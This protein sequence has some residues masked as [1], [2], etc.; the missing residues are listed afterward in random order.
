[1]VKVIQVNPRDVTQYVG[2]NNL[3]WPFNRPYLDRIGAKIPF[4]KHDYY[5]I[6]S[7][8][9][10]QPIPIERLKK[11]K[12]VKDYLTCDHYSHSMWYKTLTNQLNNKGVAI[13][14]HRKMKCHQELNLFFE[15]YL[16]P[17]I[18]SLHTEGYRSGES[19]GLVT[20]GK[21]G[22]IH[23][24]NAADHRFF[25]ARILKISPVPVR[26]KGVHEKCHLAKKSYF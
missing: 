22:E 7:A 16:N 18:E 23:K 3:R 10:R 13:H 19:I 15:Q 4:L 12:K 1:M 21:N 24:A 5:H 26:V 6:P 14:K 25:I 8:Y 11:Y 2:V 17:L 9:Y 20:I